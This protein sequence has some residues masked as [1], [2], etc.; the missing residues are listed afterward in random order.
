MFKE[1]KG[2]LIALALAGEFDVI[3]HGVN[4]FCIQGAGIARQMAE[5]FGTN[6]PDYFPEEH[7][8]M[9]GKMSKLGNIES[10][11]YYLN[12]TLQ[13]VVF[14]KPLD[15]SILTVINCYTQYNLGA[16]ARMY[17]LINCLVKLNHTFKGK[18]IGLPLIGAGIGGLNPV[19]VIEAF[20]TYLPDCN[21][22][23]VHYDKNT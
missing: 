5:I 11:D 23:V 17:A 1:I 10:L 8:V 4:C 7:R 19:D 9:V 22:T 2:N 3:C 15:Y 12:P 16:D 14:S 6:I 21:V 20:K 13:P 18:H